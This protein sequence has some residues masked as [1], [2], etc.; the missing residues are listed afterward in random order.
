M[1]HPKFAFFVVGVSTIIYKRQLGIKVAIKF[2]W[3]PLPDY[4]LGVS[5]KTGKK[6]KKKKIVFGK[7]KDKKKGKKV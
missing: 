3:T 1:K 2:W 4:K 6:V 7:E 5:W